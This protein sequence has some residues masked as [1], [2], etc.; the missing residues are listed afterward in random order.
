MCHDVSFKF[1]KLHELHLHLFYVC[2][3][4]S[5]SAG[6]PV[7]VVRSYK[8]RKYSKFAPEVGY[9]YDGIYKVVRYYP[10]VGKSGFVVWRYF[11][12]RDD[13]NPA[14][15]HK[16]GKELDVIYPPGYMQAQALKENHNQTTE[17]KIPQRQGT[18]RKAN[19]LNA[20]V[21]PS[22]KTKVEE[23]KLEDHII[24]KIKSDMVNEKLWSDCLS[25]VE[26]GKVTFLRKVEESFVC[27]CCQE[28]VYK[29]ITTDCSHNVCRPCLVRS[30]KA[31]IFTCPNCR[32]NLGQGYKLTENGNLNFTL[33]QLFPGYE[34]GR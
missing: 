34:R 23:Y 29:A 4:V 25:V 16:L 28:I 14:P 17:D 6:I 2:N 31:E 11:L 33:M 26:E 15:W 13:P 10:E 19:T 9:R 22:K 20:F 12:R 8:L 32:F 30:F 1:T 3:Y 24:D 27:V 7:R 5:V 18:K 21:K